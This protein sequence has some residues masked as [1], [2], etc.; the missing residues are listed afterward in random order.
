MGSGHDFP[1][2]QMNPRLEQDEYFCPMSYQVLARKWRPKLFADMVG[3]THVLQALTNAL[4]NNRLHH[5]YLFTG[6]R[7]V[8]KTTLAR[9]LAKCLNC[10]QGVSST[11]CGVCSACISIDEGRFVDLIEVDA[12]SRAKVDETRDLMDN[13]QYAPSIGRYKVYL[14]DEVHMFSNHSFN[15]L[16]KTLEEPPPHVKFLLATTESKKIPVTILSRCLQFNLKLLSVEQIKKQLTLILDEESVEHDEASTH[17]IAVAAAGSMRDA[18][19]LLDQA[20]SF[21][22]GVLEESQVRSML[23]TIDS[24]DLLA[25]MDALLKKDGRGLL[26]QVASFATQNPDYDAVLSELIGLLQKIAVAQVLDEDGTVDAEP[27]VSRFADEAD[28]EDIQL[29][30]QIGLNGRRDIAL[31][32]DPRSAFEMVLVRMLAFSPAAAVPGSTVRKS[33]PQVSDEPEPE[34]QSQASAGLNDNPDQ[35]PGNG[36]GHVKS[37]EQ[38][39]NAKE[40]RHIID[41]MALAG[42]VRELAGHCSLK[43]HT[44]D[45]IHLSLSP[46][47]EHLLNATQKERLIGALKAHFGENLKVE[48]TIEEPA[49]ETP[50]EIRD[51][52]EQERQKAAEQSIEN[53]PNI[54]TLEKMFDAVVDK[55]SIRPVSQQSSQQE[56]TN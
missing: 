42:L 45:R 29:F 28:K 24:V 6:T 19:S 40:W 51:R 35:V 48:L 43:Q 12:A 50:A 11:P 31:S 32:P 20:I 4:D 9:I 34:Y 33:S 15:A 8:G 10:E 22:G 3:Q 16:L 44:R 14:I 13:V 1:C 36:S 39:E 37:N 49:T 30:Y 56:E 25:L 41:D 7:G 2:P 47:R 46:K 5:A 38:A 54:K 26:Q 21:G 18:L 27:E 23:G 52:E 53:D 17:L 55:S